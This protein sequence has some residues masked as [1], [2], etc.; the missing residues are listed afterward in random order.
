MDNITFANKVISDTYVF[1]NI[2]M[3]I[4]N[5]YSINN[6]KCLGPCFPPKYIYKHPQ[7]LNELMDIDKNTCPIKFEEKINKD[8]CA[9]VTKDYDKY[10]PYETDYINYSIAFNDNAY[11]KQIY[12]INNI[13]DVKNYLQFNIETLPLLSQKRILNCI[14]NAYLNNDLFPN[15]IYINLV[16]NILKK[17]FEI[18]I[19]STKIY[20]QIM[21]NKNNNKNKSDEIKDTFDIFLFLFNK[22]CKKL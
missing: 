18:E 1:K 22:Y 20:K 14:Y 5:L 21:K 19:P 16:K 8:E 15:K 7:I 2:N 12:N 17:I 9:I 3:D 4:M 13:N 6:K 11:L 10:N